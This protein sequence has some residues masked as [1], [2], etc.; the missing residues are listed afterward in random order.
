M[1]KLWTCET[2]GTYETQAER[3]LEVCRI[4]QT[5]PGFYINGLVNK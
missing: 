4:V 3:G 2:G 1:W 5:F